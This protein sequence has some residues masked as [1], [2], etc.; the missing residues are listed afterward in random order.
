MQKNDPIDYSVN[1]Q[2]VFQRMLGHKE[3]IPGS[4]QWYE[5]SQ[6]AVACKSHYKN[7]CW[8]CEGHVYAILFW[9]KGMCYKINP[10]LPKDKTEEISFEIDRDFGPQEDAD[11]M[12]EN[13]NKKYNELPDQVPFICG[14]FTGWQ[15]RRMIELEAFNE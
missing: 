14:S 10:I 4:G 7:E 8:I 6:N 12:Y 15:Y 5:S 2:L 13:T 3:D 9:S 1:D 11:Q